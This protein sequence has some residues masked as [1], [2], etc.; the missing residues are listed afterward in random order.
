MRRVGAV[1]CTL[2][3]GATAVVL[4]VGAGA[5]EGS[6]PNSR[7]PVVVRALELVHYAPSYLGRAIRLENVVVAR[8]YSTHVFTVGDPGA[9]RDG[10]FAVV[11]PRLGVR[12]H[13]GEPLSLVGI[14]RPATEVETM[15]EIE[16]GEAVKSDLAR[17]GATVALMAS[18]IRG[19]DDREL[20]A[21]PVIHELREIP[22]GSRATDIVGRSVDLPEV[23]VMR[24]IGPRVLLV[25]DAGGHEAIVRLARTEQ[26]N[27]RLH[28]G[29]TVSL[30]GIV[31]RASS[32]LAE[33]H[34]DAVHT[35]KA[36]SVYVE[37]TD[38]EPESP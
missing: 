38:L 10:A 7:G 35:A 14:V 24:L 11:N 1:T 26:P 5:P 30:T 4:C 31:R 17:A 2:A 18:S 28:E 32:S 37:A 19:T 3:V 16:D 25:G 6:M 23:T 34:S 21:L 8:R 13:E 20:V 33:W 27:V 22:E 9:D 12:L 15:R 29:Q 36:R